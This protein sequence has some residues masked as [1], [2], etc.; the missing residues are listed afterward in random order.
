MPLWAHDLGFFFSVVT[1]QLTEILKTQKHTHL[2][3]S[4]RRDQ[5]VKPTEIDGGKLVNDNGAFKLFFLVDKLDDT[6]II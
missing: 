6:G 5:V 1:C 4:R 3:A 2:V